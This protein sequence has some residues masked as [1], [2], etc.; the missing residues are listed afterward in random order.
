VAR[1]V[2]RFW[3]EAASHSTA[4]PF[5]DA[6]RRLRLSAPNTNAESRAPCPGKVRISF[7]LAESQRTIPSSSD[8][9][10]ALLLSGLKATGLA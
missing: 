4:L 8:A 1:N 7:P 6:V 2:C 10:A 9:P 5:S 3:P